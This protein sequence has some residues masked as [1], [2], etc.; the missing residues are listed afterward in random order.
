[1]KT[2]P[3]QGKAPDLGPF[4]LAPYPFRVGQPEEV[5]SSESGKPVVFPYSDVEHGPD[6]PETEVLGGKVE[7][8]QFGQFPHIALLAGAGL[9]LRV[10]GE[11]IIASP[12]RALTPEVREYI[13]AHRD[14]IRHELFVRGIADKLE[15]VIAE[16]VGSCLDWYRDDYSAL[17]DMTGAELR[18]CVLDYMGRELYRREVLG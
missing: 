12:S 8:T 11:R 18:L 14:E 6:M 2:L 16:L 7:R 10:D 15:G 5:H 4:S 1:M 3:D 13:A 9:R 17:Q